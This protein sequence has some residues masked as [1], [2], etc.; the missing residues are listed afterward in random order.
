MSSKWKDDRMKPWNP[1]KTENWNANWGEGEFTCIHSMNDEAGP[2]WKA[3]FGA[4]YTITKVQILNRGDCCGKRLN[5]AKVMIGD[6][7]CG[8]ITNAKAGEWV[9]VKCK[10]NGNF[11]KI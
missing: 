1:V 10:A 4:S 7:L 2:W 3:N 5:E 8:T 9:T 11:L 6:N